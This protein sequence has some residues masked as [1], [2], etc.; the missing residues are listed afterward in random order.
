MS[1]RHRMWGFGVPAIDI[2]F[3]L[4]EY[5]GYRPVA[6][7]EYKHHTASEQR[8]NDRAFE[9][10]K[11]LAGK[12]GIP[13]FAVRYNPENWTFTVVPLNDRAKDKADRSQMTEEDYV[14]LLYKLRGQ[15]MPADLDIGSPLFPKLKVV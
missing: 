5:H 9:P 8:V 13:C 14:R 2:D 6:L 3:L 4:V 15:E 10:L 12:A 11:W 7:I 1:A